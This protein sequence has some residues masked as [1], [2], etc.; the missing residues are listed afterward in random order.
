MSLTRIRKPIKNSFHLEIGYFE[1]SLPL[2]KSS[3][4]TKILGELLK[5]SFGKVLGLEA[6][7]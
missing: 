7:C 3:G 1:N 2:V 6:H 5:Q 4:L